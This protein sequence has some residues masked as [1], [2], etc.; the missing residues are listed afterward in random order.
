[1]I[2][3]VSIGKLSQQRFEALTYAKHPYSD[4]T[5]REEEWYSDP[6]ENVIG[7]V[8][9]DL[10]DRDWSWVVLGRDE[11]GLFRGVDCG[12]STPS[13]SKVRR[14]LREKIR[15]HSKGGA[16]MFPQGDVLR[17]K[18][19]LFE[20]E[21][22]PEKLCK[23]FK[24]L[25]DT[26]HQA[27]RGIIREIGY[28][29]ADVDGNFVEQ[30]QTTAFNA[31]LWELFIFAFLH[32]QHV[33]L[34]RE[35]NRPD[36][37]G[38]KFGFE[39]CV[40]ASTVNPSSELSEPPPSTPE[41]I[42]KP[43]TD[44]M[45]IKFGSPLFSKL[46][47]FNAEYKMLT[48]V[49]GKAF[50]MAIADFHEES[51]MMWSSS[52]L[53]CYLYGK[54]LTWRKDAAGKLHVRNVSVKEHRWKHKTIPSNFFALPGAENISAVLFTNCATVSKFNRMGELAGFGRKDVKLFRGGVCHDHQ[55]NATEP[56]RFY[57]EV[58][59]ATCTEDWTQGVALFHNPNANHPLPPE[60]FPG[61]AHYFLRKGRIAA[62]FPDFFP[63]SSR[64]F[65]MKMVK[66]S[67][68][69]SKAKN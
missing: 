4:M 13:L 65:V 39:F 60:V 28:A 37:V 8:V 5:G 24:T 20:T 22:P 67:K 12:V 15:E 21:V 63:Y 26:H 35:Y 40:E 10:V 2:H 27:A 57:F 61:V 32:E 34:N 3:R 9:L 23:H 45:P 62:L 66:S 6:A 14:I 18:N 56:Q 33:L 25:L 68:S 7:A 50:I 29:L 64:T 59:P 30:L 52:A 53:T 44:Y 17:K 16:S 36:F 48:H 46:K 43:L 58:T 42:T 38:D 47:K 11:I 51:S 49:N 19:L 41:E 69:C 31:R 1:M 55:P 54:R